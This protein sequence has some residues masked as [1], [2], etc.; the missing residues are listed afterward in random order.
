VARRRGITVASLGGEGHATDAL[1]SGTDLAGAAEVPG[2]DTEADDAVAPTAVAADTSVPIASGVAP[3]PP[4]GPT[5]DGAGDGAGTAPQG[6][7][8]P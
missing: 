8:R 4:D 1:P 2:A 7:S 6:A 3:P 5:A